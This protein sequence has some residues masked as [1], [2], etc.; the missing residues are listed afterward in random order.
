VFLFITLKNQTKPNQTKPNQTKPN[1]TK[2]NQTKYQQNG[3]STPKW[4][5]YCLSLL[6]PTLFNPLPKATCEGETF[7]GV[8]ITVH[9]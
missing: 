3:V 7:F 8:D 9:Q 6:P 4:V 5:L 2:P 1:Q